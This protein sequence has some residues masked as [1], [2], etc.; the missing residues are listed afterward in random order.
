MY[1]M[2]DLDGSFR[3]ADRNPYLQIN[4][5]LHGSLPVLSDP[6]QTSKLINSGKLV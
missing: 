5:Y 2:R 4:I 6:L 3:K 1:D